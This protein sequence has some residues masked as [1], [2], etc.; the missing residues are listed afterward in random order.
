MLTI[1]DG[2]SAFADAISIG[3]RSRVRENSPATLTLMT[4]GPP[5]ISLEPLAPGQARVVDQNV[6][7]IGAPPR[8]RDQRGDAR[9]GRDRA[10][11]ALAGPESEELPRR[12]LASLGLARGDQHPRPALSSASAQIRPMP[13]AP[14][15]TSA[16][17]PRTEKS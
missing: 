10:A 9:F 11:E 3:A 12:R 6:Q 16:V 7:T 5:R 15:V 14:R 2:L 4:P 13:V 17:R 1:V 8:F